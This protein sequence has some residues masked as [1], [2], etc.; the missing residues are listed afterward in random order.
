M[1]MAWLKS[2]SGACDQAQTEVAA[3]NRPA[4]KVLDH[5]TFDIQPLKDF[6][7]IEQG[8]GTRC[9]LHS[10]KSAVIPARRSGIKSRYYIYSSC[11]LAIYS[12]LV[13]AGK[14]ADRDRQ[15]RND[16]EQELRKNGRAN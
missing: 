12:I 1:A 11:R 13:E 5:V 4:A 6:R 7:C 8:E 2:A 15:Y 14:A 16:T 10:A 9:Q 3:Y